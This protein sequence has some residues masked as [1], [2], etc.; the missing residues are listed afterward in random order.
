MIQYLTIVNEDPLLASNIS[1]SPPPIHNPSPLSTPPY[2][3][4]LP[5]ISQS[6]MSNHQAPLIADQTSSTIPP[7]NGGDNQY[8]IDDGLLLQLKY[9]AIGAKG[10]AYCTSLPLITLAL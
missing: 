8:G 6:K 1:T 9:K 7:V 2:L 5:Y 10:S 3:S 4:P